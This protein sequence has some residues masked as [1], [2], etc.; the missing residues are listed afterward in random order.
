[1]WDNLIQLLSEKGYS[2]PNTKLY[3]ITADCK[4]YRTIEEASV[5]LMNELDIEEYHYAESIVLFL[6]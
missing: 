5:M 3:E 4:K 6:I 1:M 2:D